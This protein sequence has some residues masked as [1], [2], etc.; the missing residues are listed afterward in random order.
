MGVLVL[1]SG[2]LFD[3]ATRVQITAPAFVGAYSGL[4]A[5]DNAN[6]LQ[7]WRQ[8]KDEWLADNASEDASAEGKNSCFF[9]EIAMGRHSSA[10][11]AASYRTA[12]GLEASI[13]FVNETADMSVACH[14]RLL[15]DGKLEANLLGDASA[16][17]ANTVCGR[18]LYRCKFSTKAQPLADHE[19][20]EEA[21]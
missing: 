10:G 6:I 15:A 5:S 9:A 18:V 14:L 21:T 7:N 17:D 13:L 8:R 20:E 16:R 4:G 11:N 12:G 2:D 19:E 1:S 3:A